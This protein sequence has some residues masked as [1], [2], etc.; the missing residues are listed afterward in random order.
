MDY[1]ETEVWGRP[2]VSTR[3]GEVAVA[4]LNRTAEVKLIAFNLEEA[5]LDALAGYTARD[6][7]TGEEFSLSHSPEVTR[8]VPAHGVV[9]LKLKGTS[10]PYNVFQYGD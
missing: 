7:W 3:S 10:L 5:G 4:L 8:E 2:L 1:G 6:L 9:V